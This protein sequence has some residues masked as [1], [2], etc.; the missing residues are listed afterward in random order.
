MLQVGGGKQGVTLG[1]RGAWP[2]IRKK[3]AGQFRR[4]NKTE[5]VMIGRLIWDRTV[6]CG[7]TTNGMTAG[8]PNTGIKVEL[9]FIFVPM[10]TFT[11]GWIAKMVVGIK[12]FY[13][14]AKS[15]I[16]KA[17]SNDGLGFRV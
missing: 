12:E 4:S 16:Y 6:T 1:S 3:F 17:S 11:I 8:P 14:R 10:G 5:H 2:L 13:L 15:D 7:G 9:T